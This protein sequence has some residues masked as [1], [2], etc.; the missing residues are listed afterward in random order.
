MAIEIKLEYRA[1][2]IECNSLEGTSV[3]CIYIYFL[4]RE[5]MVWRV[6]GSVGTWVGAFCRGFLF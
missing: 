1:S 2:D 6:G 3:G 5:C 4:F